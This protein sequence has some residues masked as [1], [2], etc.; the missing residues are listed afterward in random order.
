MIET[1]LLWQLGRHNGITL[2]STSWKTNVFLLIA[3][4]ICYVLLIWWITWLVLCW[5]SSFQCLLFNLF[6]CCLYLAV[7]WRQGRWRVKNRS[8]FQLYLSVAVQRRQ[9]TLPVQPKSLLQSKFFW[10]CSLQLPSM[11]GS[12]TVHKVVKKDEEREIVRRH[13]LHHRSS[14]GAVL[15]IA[16]PSHLLSGPFAGEQVNSAHNCFSLP[17]WA[18]WYP[19]SMIGANSHVLISLWELLLS[20]S[21]PPAGADV[22][23]GFYLASCGSGTLVISKEDVLEA[24]GRVFKL[25]THVQYT[26]GLKGCFASFCWKLS[27]PES[28]TS[29]TDARC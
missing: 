13:Q 8:W 2:S 21:S 4:F 20:F 24:G 26:H 19:R 10:G 23:M 6:S 25:T 29:S 11:F 9:T 16:C 18:G 7:C 28:V 5:V 15:V 12:G 27:K 22:A 3:A 1:Q 17:D 14:V